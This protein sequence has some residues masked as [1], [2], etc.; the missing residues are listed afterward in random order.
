MSFDLKKTLA[1]IAKTGPNMQEAQKGGGGDYEPPVEGACLLRFVGYVEIGKQESNW[2]GQVKVKDKV[3]LVFEVHGKNYPVKELDDGTKVVHRI[4]IT[5]TLSLSEKAN[6]FK[7]FRAMS[8]GRSDITHMAQMLGEPFRGRIYHNK[9]EDG[10]VF[11]RLRNDAGYSIAPPYVED[12]ETGES[13]KV[14]VPE[15][16]S[17]LRLFVWDAASKEMW[18]SLFIDGEYEEGKTK[19]VFQEAITKAKNFPGSPIYAILQGVYGDDDE[20]GTNEVEGADGGE[21]YEEEEAPPAPKAKAKPKGKVKPKA[22]DDDPLAG[23]GE[24]E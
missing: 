18:D 3:Q 9:T 14:K 7:L 13:R 6:F 5:E 22:E 15:A 24:D 19:N 1:H 11:A 16:I 2:K 21:E 10:R 23:I 8:N 17:P 20:D 12:A 4:K